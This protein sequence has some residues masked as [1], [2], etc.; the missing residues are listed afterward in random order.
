MPP[1]PTRAAHELGLGAAGLAHGDA[2]RCRRRR[3][4]CGR[5]RRRSRWRRPGC[6]ARASC[7]R[8]AASLRWPTSSAP[9]ST[10]EHAGAADQHGLQRRPPRAQRRRTRSTQLGHGEVGELARAARPRARRLGQHDV[11]QPGDAE[12]AGRPAR[13]RCTSPGRATRARRRRRPTRR[14]RPSG[15]S[16]RAISLQARAARA[17][18]RRRPRPGTSR[19][20]IGAVLALDDQLGVEQQRDV[21]ARRRAR[22]ARSA[23][24]A[25]SMSV[26]VA[27][28]V[29]S[30]SMPVIAPSALM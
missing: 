17:A 28:G 9:T 19:N 25:P 15:P 3:G 13:G 16:S 23:T 18:A 14:A 8:T 30:S 27:G 10:G 11:R 2:L 1:P 12:R 21:A 7:S 4:S 20:D 5:G 29:G 26:A 6:A 22:P 24:I